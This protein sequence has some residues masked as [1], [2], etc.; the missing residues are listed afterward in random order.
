MRGDSVPGFRRI[1]VK[2]EKWLNVE[3][4]GQH[5]RTECFGSGTFIGVLR[6]MCN[7]AGLMADSDGGGNAQPDTIEI[8]RRG[9]LSY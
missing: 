8:N 1:N 2:G 4:F 7:K 6:L 5:E 9:G 3:Y